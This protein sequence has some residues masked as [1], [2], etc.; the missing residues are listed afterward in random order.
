MFKADKFIDEST[1]KLKEVISGKALIAFSGGVDST[2]CAALVNNAI[3][4][5]LIA[6]HVDT[7]YMRKNES[8]NVKELMEK[9]KLNYR[10]VDASKEFYSALKGVIEPEKKRKII[11]EKFIRIFENVADA[12]KIE[13][14]GRVIIWEYFYLFLSSILNHNTDDQSSN[15]SCIL[16]RFIMA[17][18]PIKKSIPQIP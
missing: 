18:E 17:P 16:F 14:R 8:K 2:V 13:Y 12:E 5:Q 10:Y 7:G 11:G 9:M 4:K 1:L 3:G 6:V 15:W